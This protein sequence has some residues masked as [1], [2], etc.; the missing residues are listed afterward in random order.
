MLDSKTTPCAIN[1][2]MKVETRQ[3]SAHASYKNGIDF[4]GTYDN[5]EFGSIEDRQGTIPKGKLPHQLLIKMV[6]G[7]SNCQKCP[8]YENSRSKQ[9]DSSI[10]KQLQ[11]KQ[12]QD[13]SDNTFDKIF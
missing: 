6:S 13:D 12:V 1:E 7:A 2:M 3:N 8:W 9:G 5:I 10:P 11:I 4:A